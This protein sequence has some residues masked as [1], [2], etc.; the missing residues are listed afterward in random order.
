MVAGMGEE[1]C[2]LPMTLPHSLSFP[3]SLSHTHKLPLNEIGKVWVTFSLPFP[4]PFPSPLPPSLILSPLPILLQ[5]H[6]HTHTL[7]LFSGTAQTGTTSV[8]HVK[9]VFFGGGF[10]HPNMLPALCWT[11]VLVWAKAEKR[12]GST[13]REEEIKPRWMMVK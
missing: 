3:L 2:F 6:S 4:F 10:Y 5:S 1:K 7:A 9:K 13:G 8:L 11:L 12:G